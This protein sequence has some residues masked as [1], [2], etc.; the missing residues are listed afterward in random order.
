MLKDQIEKERHSK[1]TLEM[2][3]TR[4]IDYLRGQL[5]LMRSVH[6]QLDEESTKKASLEAALEQTKAKMIEA[7]EQATEANSL[8]V[9]F[10]SCLLLQC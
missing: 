3:L 4:E 9:S 6:S 10:I 7:Q 1:E 5:G 2:S 8:K